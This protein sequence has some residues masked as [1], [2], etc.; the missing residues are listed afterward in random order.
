MREWLRRWRYTSA[1]HIRRDTGDATLSTMDR[2]Q[3][4]AAAYQSGAI[5]CGAHLIDAATMPVQGPSRTSTDTQTAAPPAVPVPPVQIRAA[6]ASLARR[7]ALS[8][9]NTH[10]LPVLTGANA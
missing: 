1:H 9:W 2:Q 3:L 10:A 8:R 6:Q 5:T 7:E 4:L